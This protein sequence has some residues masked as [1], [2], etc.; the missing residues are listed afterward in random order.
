MASPRVV[1]ITGGNEGIGW[2]TVKALLES[3]K[4]YHIFMGSR[5]M[6]KAEL[7]MEKLRKE[8][9][10]VT[11]TVETLQVDVTSDESIEKAFEKVQSSRGYID[12]L[13][14]NAGT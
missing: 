13:L 3:Q 12:T 7:A 6:E 14:N 9:P 2:E 8:C 4:P 1:L 5:S 10:K 11:N